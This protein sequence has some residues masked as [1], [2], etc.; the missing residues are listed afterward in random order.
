[1]QQCTEHIEIKI[2]LLITKT[3]KD[4]TGIQRSSLRSSLFKANIYG[5]SVISGTCFIIYYY[6]QLINHRFTR[7]RSILDGEVHN[8][9]AWA[10]HDHH[11]SNGTHS[12]VTRNFYYNEINKEINARSIVI[13]LDSNY[14]LRKLYS[15]VR[16]NFATFKFSWR[17]Q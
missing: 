4:N 3:K 11:N 12:N 14:W 6:F 9:D 13:I 17:S 15:F 16:V 2:F 5:D 1:M 10:C 7:F 8:D